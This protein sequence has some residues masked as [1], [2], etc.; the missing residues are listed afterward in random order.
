MNQF[1]T[2]NTPRTLGILAAVVAV[3]VAG[4]VWFARDR[5]R[6]AGAAGTTPAAA[7]G[8]AGAA[9][10][11]ASSA[12]AAEPVTPSQPPPSQAAPTATPGG[13]A[14]GAGTPGAGGPGAGG[15]GN[16]GSGGGNAGSGGGRCSAVT[17]IAAR[18]TGE[19]SGT[20]FLLGRVAR[21]V[22]AN[23]SVRLTIVGLNYPATANF[24][25]SSRQGIA[26]LR[27]LIAAERAGACLVLLGYSQGA[28]VVGDA[29]A[30]LG[31]TDAA[32]VR[33][34]AMFGDPR[35]NSAEPYNV[36][37]FASNSRGVNRR[38]TGQLAAFRS[39]IQNYC[40]GGDTVCQGSGAQGSGSHLDYNAFVG[41]A[42]SFAAAKV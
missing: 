41:A 28:I 42:A 29:L 15:G 32:K 38:P 10:P 2:G 20:G 37:S 12:P 30:A 26:E 16:A 24:A 18:G 14:P 25:V 19:P 27:R 34:V 39:R 4:S 8:P 11:A 6:P 9:A 1:G 33:A 7:A 17:V 13:G 31:S 40:N 21:Q 3:L 5:A 36:G 22:D 23:V 35:F